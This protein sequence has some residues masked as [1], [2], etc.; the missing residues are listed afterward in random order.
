MMSD[1]LRAF[2]AVFG[3][4]DFTRDPVSINIHKNSYI[5]AQKPK[6]GRRIIVSIEE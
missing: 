1:A 3:T 2:A 4:R 6:I 5:T